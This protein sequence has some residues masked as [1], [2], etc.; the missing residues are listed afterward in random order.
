MCVEMGAWDG[1]EQSAWGLVVPPSLARRWGGLLSVRGSL[2]SSVAG[3]GTA[4]L[5]AGEREK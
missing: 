5:N 1:S 3:V 2:P 4:W